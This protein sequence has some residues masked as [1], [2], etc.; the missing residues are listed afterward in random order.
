MSF[1]HN[2]DKLRFDFDDSWRVL[3]WDEHSAYVGGLKQFP[4]T[5]AVDFYGLH[6]GVPHFIEVKDLRGYR[7]DNKDRLKS[8]QLATEVACKVRDTLAA[9]VWACDR[10]PLDARELGGFLKPLVNRDEKVPVILWLEEDRPIEPVDASTIAE[11][12]K[13]A[14]RWLNAKV[15]VTC[16]ALSAQRPIQGLTVTSLP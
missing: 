1:T 8:G 14:L 16:R 13:R 5:K 12:I 10:A 9:M 7:I 2:E 4:G 15:M 6:V 11:Q 3:K